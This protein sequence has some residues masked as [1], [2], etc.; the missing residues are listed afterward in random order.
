MLTS[1]KMQISLTGLGTPSK[2]ELFFLH[3]FTQLAQQNHT[4]VTLCEKPDKAD[5]ILLLYG[6][7]I[8]H[9]PTPE[10][11]ALLR[12]R[13]NDIYVF[14]TCPIPIFWIQG[15][16]HAL[17]LKQAKQNRFRNY[18]SPIIHPEIEAAN[19][20][21]VA[22]D[23]F[24]SFFGG[25]TSWVRKKLY[26]TDYKMSDVVIK[27]TSYHHEWDISQPGWEVHKKDY[28]S[29]LTRSQFILC[30]R[31]A[32]P[33]AVR[34]YEGMQ[35]SRPVVLL[36]DDFPLPKGPDWEKFMIRVSEKNIAHIPDILKPYRNQW[37][38]MGIIA[39]QEWEKWFS[40]DVWLDRMAEICQDI[41]SK[42]QGSEAEYLHRF[43]MSQSLQYVKNH[44]YLTSRKMCRTTLRLLGLSKMLHLNRP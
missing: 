3:Q 35:C 2:T 1:N 4:G 18:C 32:T 28:V 39:R 24:F 13:A 36:S 31:G 14:E 33:N 15:I 25:S 30:P 21:N 27:D 9:R 22:P 44:T 10:E 42:R 20:A 12:E 17:N 37:R 40:P 6:A 19:K 43:P 38:E 23:L 26:F 16:Y 8:F 7:T 11:Q 41:A 34:I 5:I 29:T